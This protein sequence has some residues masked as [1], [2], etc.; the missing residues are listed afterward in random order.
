MIPGRV[1]ASRQERLSIYQLMAHLPIRKTILPGGAIAL[2]LLAFPF[3][4]ESGI[5]SPA[6]SRQA[7]PAAGQAVLEDPSEQRS[8]RGWMPAG[9]FRQLLLSAVPL[10]Q[11]RW[12]TRSF[13]EANAGPWQRESGKPANQIFV[14]GQTVKLRK[15]SV[16]PRADRP[17]QYGFRTDRHNN[18]TAMT[19][20]VAAESG[21]VEGQDYVRGDRFVGSDGK[22]YFTA[23]LLGDPIETTIRAIDQG[24]MYTQSGRGRWRYL[25]R[26]PGA[27]KWIGLTREQKVAIV[28]LM[29]RM[30]GGSGRFRALP[31][32]PAGVGQEVSPAPAS[33]EARESSQ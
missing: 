10:F 31:A 25:Y 27:R 12:D 14:A 18:P 16:G 9:S 24:G 33:R 19:T 3:W 7:P 29:Y 5:G 22:T 32:V 20:D 1:L 26:I 2:L 8:T 23:R 13:V 17:T 11:P 21:L 4:V 30:E 28:L 6:M 15:S